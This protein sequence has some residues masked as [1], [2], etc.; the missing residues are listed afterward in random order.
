MICYLIVINVNTVVVVIIIIATDPVVVIAT[1][2]SF[3]YSLVLASVPTLRLAY[4]VELLVYRVEK[5][6]DLHLRL[7][8]LPTPLYCSV[9][10]RLLAWIPS[11]LKTLF[12]LSE[13]WRPRAKLSSAPFTNHPHKSMLS[14]TSMMFLPIMYNVKP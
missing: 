1:M 2:I 4:Q 6:N 11:W 5:G 8:S 14:L 3:F 10:N 7:R 12:I 13:R 9:M